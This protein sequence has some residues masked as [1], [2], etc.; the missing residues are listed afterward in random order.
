[1]RDISFLDYWLAVI[2]ATKSYRLMKRNILLCTVIERLNN[3]NIQHTL[4]MQ[5]QNPDFCVIPSNKIT[6]QFYNLLTIQ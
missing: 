3:Y 4:I 5:I 6:G 2:V 1:M